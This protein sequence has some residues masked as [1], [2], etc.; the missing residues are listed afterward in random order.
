[1]DAIFDNDEVF[2]DIPK[3]EITLPS[4]W[5]I[6]PLV[7][8]PRVRKLGNQL[9]FRLYSMSI[10]VTFS[11]QLVRQR[12]DSYK[13]GRTIH[14]CQIELV[15]KEPAERLSYM[16]RICGLRP[17]ETYIKITRNPSLPGELSY[18]YS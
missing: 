16:L 8:P 14:S 10:P 7:Y 15:W 3:E 2:L 17:A 4:G 1:M 9:Y 11:L 18:G 6:Q 13:P 12:V 5:T